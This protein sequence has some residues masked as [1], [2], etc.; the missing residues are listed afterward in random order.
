MRELALGLGPADGVGRVGEAERRLVVDDVEELLDARIGLGRVLVG[1]RDGQSH[2]GEAGAIGPLGAAE[3]VLDA[4]VDDNRLAVK[5]RGAVAGHG[6]QDSIR[7]S[8]GR[9]SKRGSPPIQ[10]C[11]LCI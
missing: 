11:R 8:P 6:G 4:R 3:Q 9:P 2:R 1:H 5:A 10:P 7:R